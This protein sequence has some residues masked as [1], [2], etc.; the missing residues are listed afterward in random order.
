M[1]LVRLRAAAAPR[2]EVRFKATDVVEMFRGSMRNLSMI[3]MI[4]P[5]K[6]TELVA[7]E[8]C[9]KPEKKVTLPAP[10]ASTR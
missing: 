7:V 2:E 8:F 5:V 10:K 6:L 9:K 1:V 4:P 3:I